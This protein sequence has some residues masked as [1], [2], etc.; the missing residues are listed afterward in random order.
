LLVA[1]C[2]NEEGVTA[3]QVS[4]AVTNASGRIAALQFDVI[5]PAGGGWEGAGGGV[6]CSKQVEVQLATFNDRG[7]GRMSAALV[8]LAGFATPTVVATCTYR[9]LIEPT[10]DQFQAIVIDASGTDASI[11]LDPFPEMAVTAVSPT[12]SL[13]P[14]PSTTVTTTLPGNAAT[15]YA[16]TFGV[17]TS[18][19]QLAALQFDARYRRDGGGW[20]GAGGRVVC[21]TAVPIALA[22]FNDR[23]GAW[24]S[25]ALVDLEGFPTPADVATCIFKTRVP[26][27]PEDFA[28][29]VIDAS[30]P[31]VDLPLDPFPAMAV[32]SIEPLD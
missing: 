24:L 26:L 5:G 9:S 29:E 31:D 27:L 30:G 22:T 16:V 1:G 2:G 19:G 14:F 21:T 3:F 20:L 12:R 10:P 18:S 4:I 7:G 23:G 13:E 32:T 15:P 28:V 6:V 17:T 11:P 25:A 8:D